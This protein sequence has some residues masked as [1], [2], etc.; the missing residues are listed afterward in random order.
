MEKNTELI[1]RINQEISRAVDE[2]EFLTL[3]THRMTQNVEGHL[4]FALEEILRKMEKESW[5]HALYTIIKE[6]VINGCK[7]NQ[8][9]IF[10]DEQEYSN[11]SKESY[12]SGLSAYRE[13]FSED[14]S[15]EYGIKSR[16]RGY[17]VLISFHYTPEGMT[18]EVSNN[19]PIFEQEERSMREKLKKAM[20]YN[21]LAEFYME[22]AE[23]ENPD[24]EGAGLGLALIV[25][26]LKNEGIDPDLFR[27]I[28]DG[29]QTIAR[30]EIP[31][32]KE[33]IGKREATVL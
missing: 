29:N 23:S 18:V 22:Q 15:N 10:F 9:K 26:L 25:I 21:D 12:S 11:D 6:L 19:T 1:D 24:T 31:F 7:A 32:S 16:N 13:S 14:M 20:E 30:I 33:F 8:K 17:Y 27:I 28:I 2:S 3:R 5:V 4:L